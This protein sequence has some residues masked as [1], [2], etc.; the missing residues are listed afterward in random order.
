LHRGAAQ[1]EGA[2][3]IM[4]HELTYKLPYEQAA[5]L[6]RVG[7]R[8]A[9]TTIRVIF[10]GLVGIIFAMGIVLSLYG[11]ELNKWMSSIGMPFGVSYMLPF[12]I[13][14]AV[15]IS[16]V[17][18]KKITTKQAKSRVD[19]DQSIKLTFEDEGLRIVGSE[20]EF[21][22]K[23]L[24]IHQLFVV[25]DGIVVLAG[26]ML[27]AVPNIAFPTLEEKRNFLQDVYSRLSEKARSLSEKEVRAV[28]GHDTH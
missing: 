23:W 19:F 24:G 26:N 14:L 9:F 13:L 16:Y 5:K 10:W 20:I 15:V 28:I 22:I 21:L 7:R 2:E 8:K 25:R 11:H 17:Y 6:C 27:F 18:M 4:K 1:N 12:A 3:H